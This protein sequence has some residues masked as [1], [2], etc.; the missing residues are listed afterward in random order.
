MVLVLG[1]VLSG[2][3]AHAASL[4]IAPL[5]YDDVILGKGEVKKGFVD[6]SNPDYTKHTVQLSVKAFRQI[7][8]EGGL[9]FYANEQ[10]AAGIQLDF[11]KITLENRGAMR[12]YF[13]LNGAKLPEGDVFAAIVAQTVPDGQATAAQSVSVGTLL[14]IQ[15]GTPAS[16]TAEITSFSASWLQVSDGLAAHMQV[17][18]P[19]DGTSTTGY[20]PNIVIAAQPYTTTNVKG[21]LLFAGRTRTVDYYQTGN[22]FGPLYLKASVGSSSKGR[23]VF[24]VTGY[25]RWL[26]PVLVVCFIVSWLVFRRGLLRRRHKNR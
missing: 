22:Y 11:D 25:W 13:V 20:Y 7:D 17:R 18:N 15:N 16:H 21:P 24:A 12:V 10:V 23:L 1:V 9:E 6:I 3:T 8:D 5:I 2:Q 4:K 19:A 26:A 14:V